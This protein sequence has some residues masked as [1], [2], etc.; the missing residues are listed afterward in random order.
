V[1]NYVPVSLRPILHDVVDH[2]VT[3][4]QGNVASCG[5]RADP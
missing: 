2:R 5:G 1:L 3:S 4:D